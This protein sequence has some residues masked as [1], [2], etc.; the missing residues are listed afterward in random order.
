MN[1]KRK[2]IPGWRHFKCTDCGH[3]WREASRDCQSLSVS[4]C[5]KADYGSIPHVMGLGEVIDFTPRPDW[6]LDESGNLLQYHNYE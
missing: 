5:P 6:E 3:E 2:L 4:G 1:T